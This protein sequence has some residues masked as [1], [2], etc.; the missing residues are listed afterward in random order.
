MLDSN[1]FKK[2]TYDN[3]L[4]EMST[5]AKELFGADA[6][7][8]ERG[9][10]GRLLRIMAWFLSLSWQAIEA[11]Y[12]SGFRS[13][14][15][16]KNL[17]K[18]LPYAGITRN[19]ADYATGEVLLKG[20]PNYTQ[21][22]GLVVGTPNDIDFEIYEDVTLDSKGEA[23]VKIVCAQIGSIGNVP[24]GAINVIVTP[25]S[26][27]TSVTNLHDTKG[28]RERETDQ[29][30][31]ERANITVEGLGSGTTAAIRAEL[32]KIS[33]V[34][35][36]FVIENDTLIT[37]A[38]GTPGKSVQSF[39]LGGSDVDVAQAILRKKSGGIRPYGTTTTI[40]Y[41]VGGHPHEVGF[42]RASEKRIYARITLKTDTS[43]TTN[44]E[45]LVKDA[46]VGYIGGVRTNNT[47]AMGLNMGEKVIYAK[48][49][50]NVISVN[51]VTDADL[52]F[53]TDGV[54]YGTENIE[55]LIYEVAQIDATDI[56]V[57][58]NV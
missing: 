22:A 45:D 27:I 18:L 1:G 21:E 15:E 36:A 4:S 43:F 38:Y 35:A 32:L 26:N 30:A 47:L 25:N 12:H 20:T 56:E 31:R 34:R 40:A 52:E 33:D 53:S 46:L 39:V 7:V 3:L 5:H 49:L 16:E 17:D 29:E 6:N 42:T 28:G 41:D 10:L 54:I 11:V 37:D 23:L 58:L 19:L 55:T 48:A 14:A 2:K 50:A 8:T 57:T 24:A 9:V 13:S 44:G 51:G